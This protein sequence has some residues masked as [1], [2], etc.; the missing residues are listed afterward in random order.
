MDFDA[1]KALGLAL[2]L[3]EE[4]TSYGTPALKVK[5]KL[6][7]RLKE[8]GESVAV[9]TTWEERERLL[10]VEPETYYITD[11]YRDH[12]WV[13]VR[14]PQAHPDGAKLRLAQAWL[15]AAPKSLL[16]LHGAS[17]ESICALPAARR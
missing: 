6:M 12:P 9:R 10:T 11:H 4:S 5:G 16:K 2:P 14:L 15:L 13:L 3:V 17:V 1:F 8:D 7:A